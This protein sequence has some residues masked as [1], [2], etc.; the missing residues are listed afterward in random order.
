MALAG[1]AFLAL[2]GRTL[3]PSHGPSVTSVTPRGRSWLAELF[4]PAGSAAIGRPVQ[5]IE[6]M[7]RGRGRVV[8][9]IRGDSSLR[10]D[11]DAIRLEAGD[12]VVV[13]TSEIELMG[14]REGVASGV[15]ILG[16]EPGGARRTRVM[17]VLVAPRSRVVG[18]P[19]SSLNW[20]RRFG[21]Y[22]I[23]LHRDGGQVS[24]LETA[25]LTVGD[26]LLI[27]GAPGDITRATEELRLLPLSTSAA[28]AY[29]RNRAPI[30][31]AVLGGVVGLA[32]LD[33][34]PILPL[35]LIGVALVFMTGCLDADEGIDAMD[36]RLLLLVI[37]ML[38]LGTALDNSGALG[39]VVDW[40]APLLEK[41]S[42]LLALALVY[43]LTSLLTELVTNNAVAVLMAPIAAGVATSL[44]LDPR[45][46]VVAVMFGASA[47]FAT[48][49]GYQTNTLVFN[50]GGYRFGDFLRIGVPMNLIVGAVTVTLIPLWPLEIEAASR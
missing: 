3:L 13:R 37:S 31:L 27:D 48:P 39:L 16:A 49:I 33:V 41:A 12:R 7:T 35:A 46:F 18:R 4:I 6:R 45:P 29:R 17:E 44:G 32:A 15:E 42:P 2:A 50:A 11:R 9:V 38:M 22:P 47:S 8:D 28:R 23:A 43:A 20:R 5:A 26:I 34:A 10:R 1:G 14:F 25:I 19:L 40:L 30:A 24:G 21:V 36:G